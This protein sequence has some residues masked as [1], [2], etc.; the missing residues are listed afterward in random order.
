MSKFSIEK[1]L[2][3]KEVEEISIAE[4]KVLVRGTDEIIKEVDKSSFGGGSS[5][6]VSKLELDDLISNNSLIPGSYYK[7]SG[8]HPTLYDD[9]TSSG[10]TIFIKATASNMLEKNGHGL[11]YNP[12]YDQKADGFGIYGTK[13]ATNATFERSHIFATGIPSYGS[14]NSFHANSSGVL[15]TSGNDGRI[16][17]IENGIVTTIVSGLTPQYGLPFIIKKDDYLYAIPAIYNEPYKMVRIDYNGNVSDFCNLSIR[18]TNMLKDKDENIFLWSYYENVIKYVDIHGNEQHFANVVNP[19]DVRQKSNGD[20]IVL[21]GNNTV[22]KVDLTGTETLICTFPYTARNLHIDGLDNIFVTASGDDPTAMSV[23]HVYRFLNGGSSVEDIWSGTKFPWFLAGDSKNVLYISTHYTDSI[24]KITLDLEISVIDS[25]NEGITWNTIHLDRDDN[26]Y[27]HC[28]NNM[29]L[30]YLS[31][32]TQHSEIITNSLSRPENMIIDKNSLSSDMLLTTFSNNT[33]N[34]M[35]RNGTITTFATVG[36]GP[37]FLCQDSAGNTFV[38]NSEDVTISKIDPIGSVML[39]AS[40]PNDSYTSMTIDIN[41][42]IYLCRPYTALI[43]ITPSGIVSNFGS[44]TSQSLVVKTD[45]NNNIF[46]GNFSEKTILKYTPTGITTIYATTDSYIFDLF[47]TSDNIIFAILYSGIIIKIEP[48]GSWS[49]FGSSVGANP[50]SIRIIDNNIYTVSLNENKICKT[51]MS[52]MNTVV[53]S[54]MVS[55]P[56]EVLVN[57]F[58]EIF[59]INN[60]GSNITKVSSIVQPF[61]INENITANNGAKGALLTNYNDT[62]ISPVTFHMISGDWSTAT[63]IEG[64]NSGAIANI[65]NVVFDEAYNSGDQTI[66]GG[67]KWVNLTGNTGYN[68]D[69]FRLNEDWSKLQ[70]DEQ[71]YNQALDII[72]YDYSNNWISRRY[73]TESGN[74]IKFN[75]QDNNYFGLNQSTIAYFMF[76]NYN[77]EDNTQ[78]VRRIT[79]NHGFLNNINFIGRGQTFMFFDEGSVQNYCTFAKGTS[80]QYKVVLGQSASNSNHIFEDSSHQTLIE[81][82]QNAAL[83]GITFTYNVNLSKITVEQQSAIDTITILP[84]MIL[85]NDNITKTVYQRPDGTPKI[86]YYDNDDNLVINN[87]TD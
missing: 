65:K 2:I 56:T 35:T 48:D 31:A 83:N 17:R 62:N 73:E 36:N 45:S 33:V 14:T 77:Y 81:L 46:V 26:L 59:A 32:K 70:Y 43:K 16:A 78:G 38:Y 74:D 50:Y 69:D 24:I 29:I 71:N 11:F 15:F 20:I 1:K 47:I 60:Y 87:I 79:V 86:R 10:T 28:E 63:Q 12:K 54:T 34:K 52:D 82:K 57:T 68:Y 8:V 23:K 49:P 72:E 6:S 85:A 58:G 44:E 40:L 9:G 37:R 27:I 76:G 18:S 55:S 41:D 39:F 22:V 25:A 21:K 42:N 61:S 53:I 19:V 13:E 3:L 66:W 64:D 84:D 80:Y 30:R 7:V 5:I 75:N 67:Y 51:S 4:E